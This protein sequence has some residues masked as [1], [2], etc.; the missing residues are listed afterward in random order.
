MDCEPIKRETDHLQSPRQI[1]TGKSFKSPPLEIRAKS[2]RDET[3][4]IKVFAREK[5]VDLSAFQ[6]DTRRSGIPDSAAQNIDALNQLL[7]IAG[8]TRSGKA[9]AAT[10]DWSL[11]D[12]T[13]TVGSRP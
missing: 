5:R 12:L 10:G 9:N 4:V 13:I 6:Q 3:T 8:G 1:E 7:C 2:G 11:T